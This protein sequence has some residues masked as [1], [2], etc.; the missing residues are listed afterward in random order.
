MIERNKV[1]KFGM[2]SQANQYMQDLNKLFNSNTP[3]NQN[4]V[5]K[6]YPMKLFKIPEHYARHKKL[7][8]GKVRLMHMIRNK[9]K[10]AKK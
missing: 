1:D 10:V 8:R 2:F 3:S 4:H 6:T 9:K 7:K 5:Q